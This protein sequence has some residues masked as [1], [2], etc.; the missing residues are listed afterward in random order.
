MTP[1]QVKSLLKVVESGSIR[2]ASNH[3]HL[4]PSS[5]SAQLS[6]LASELDVELFRSTS[7]G[8]VLTAAG[9][10]L[11]PEFREFARLADAIQLRAREMA[12]LPLGVLRL[13]APSSMCIY[14]LPAI[15]DRLQ[16]QA[17]GLEVVLAHEPCDY[18][19]GL[20]SAE[21]D[22]AIEVSI[23][24]P[25]SRWQRVRLFTE[26]VIYVCH[27]DRWQP[28]LTGL[29]ELAGQA[30]IT[31]EPACSYRREAARRFEAAGLQLR[32]RQ[33]FSNVEVIRRCVLANMGIALLPRC[34]V[35]DDLQS[36][37][38]RQFRVDDE[39]CLFHSWL[40]YPQARQNDSALAALRQAIQLE[41]QDS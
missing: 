12:G 19:A 28:R 1:R 3:L 41:C 22:A 10:R 20:H 35:A 29:S 15:I 36:G 14:R 37:A 38:L 11:M 39:P 6:E 24:P 33:N 21:L 8:L 27:P 7:R 13:Y 32:P 26:D 17:P 25:D 34:V 4:A 23:A 16:R 40:I 18:I 2:Q 31:T 5:I 30:L 9:Q